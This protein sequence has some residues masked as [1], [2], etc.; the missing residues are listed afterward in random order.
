MDYGEV[1]LEPLHDSVV[2]V[3]DDCSL[4]KQLASDPVPDD[5][6]LVKLKKIDPIHLSADAINAKLGLLSEKD[7]G[8]VKLTFVPDR[9][10]TSLLNPFSDLSFRAEDAEDGFVNIYHNYGKDEENN[11][12]DSLLYVDTA[13]TN[14]NGAKF[15]AFK[16]ETKTISFKPFAIKN[17]HL[18]WPNGVGEHT[19]YNMSFAFESNHSVSD[20]TDVRYGIREITSDKDPANGGRRFFVNGQKVYITGGNYINSDWLLRLSP[21]RYRDEVRFHAEMNLRMIRVWGGALLERPEFYNACDEYGI[22]VFQDLWGSG[23]CNGAW[24]DPAKKDSRERRWEYPDNHALEYVFNGG[25]V[26][27]RNLVSLIESKKST[28]DDSLI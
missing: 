5:A 10:K 3:M 8:N 19:L 27:K 12:I 21:E 17:P 6:L 13:Y 15:L 2:Y 20:K 25:I 23:D 24:I 18:W 4:L 9:N 26:G 7:Y 11:P 16:H 1:D 14:V 28:M 22:L